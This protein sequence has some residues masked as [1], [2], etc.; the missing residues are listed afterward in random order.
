M[1]LVKHALKVILPDNKKINVF[2]LKIPN[3]MTYSVLCYG[4]ESN[5]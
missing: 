1:A 2:G 5:Y 4:N 3:Y